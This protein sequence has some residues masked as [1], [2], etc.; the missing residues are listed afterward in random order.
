[1]AKVNH[2]SSDGSIIVSTEVFI[3][4]VMED[5]FKDSN[6]PLGEPK[7]IRKCFPSNNLML[8]ELPCNLE[9]NVA[10]EC[11]D[12]VKA[13]KMNPWGE[14]LETEMITDQNGEFTYSLLFGYLVV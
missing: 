6:M 9:V 8:L 5:I 4:D 13:S 11:L 1:M 12:L 7:V 10:R 14:Q 3:K 2:N